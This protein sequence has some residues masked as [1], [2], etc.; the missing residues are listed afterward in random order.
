MTTDIDYEELDDALRRCGASW[1]AAQVHGLL[2]SRLA[3]AGTEAGFG[4]LQAV[5]EGTDPSNALTAECETLLS[6]LFERTGSALSARL[7]EFTPLLPDDAAA[8]DQRAQALA[9][10]CEGYLHGL[11]SADHGDELRARLS[12]EPIADIIKDMLQITRAMAEKVDDEE[13]EE[14]YMQLVE[15][16][17]VSAQLVFEELEDLRQPQDTTDAVH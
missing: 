6:T 7:S 4:W 12:A 2:S 9:H 11:V 16:L 13:A 17:R 3:V 8:P 1:D 14:A 5:L 15:Y 10:W